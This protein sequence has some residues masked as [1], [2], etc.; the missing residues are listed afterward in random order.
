MAWRNGEFCLALLHLR[1]ASYLFN[2]R[3]TWTR[4]YV[5]GNETVEKRMRRMAANG[6]LRA[7][8]GQKGKEQRL[9]AQSFILARNKEVEKEVKVRVVQIH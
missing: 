5:K 3:E 4:F 9:W 2:I 6:G 7:L 1:N 8:R